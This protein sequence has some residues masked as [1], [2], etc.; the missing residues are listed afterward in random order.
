MRAKVRRSPRQSAGA[1]ARAGSNPGGS[2]PLHWWHPR[3][4]LGLTLL[5]GMLGA[6]AGVVL[7]A[8]D[9]GLAPV[10]LLEACGATAGAGAS[11]GLVLGLVLGLLLGL[12]HRYLLP[13]AVHPRRV[14]VRYRRDS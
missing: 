10:E 5:G 7:A 11:A 4:T 12:V 9:R 1:G 13:Q 6:V 2:A 3:L 14:W 8:L